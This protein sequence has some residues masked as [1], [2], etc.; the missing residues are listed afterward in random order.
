MAAKAAKR[1]L[2][3]ALEN[4]DLMPQAARVIEQSKD[5]DAKHVTELVLAVCNPALYGK[6]ARWCDDFTSDRTAVYYTWDKPNTN[7]VWPQAPLVEFTRFCVA[8]PPAGSPSPAGA[9]VSFIPSRN[10]ALQLTNFLF[11]TSLRRTIRENKNP[12]GAYTNYDWYGVDGSKDLIIASP[13]TGNSATTQIIPGGASYAGNLIAGQGQSNYQSAIAYV[14]GGGGG[15][16][17]TANTAATRPGGGTLGGGNQIPQS[18]FLP[19]HG[20]FL[21]GQTY[22]G[23]TFIWNDGFSGNGGTAQVQNVP[24][25]PTS[26]STNGIWADSTDSATWAGIGDI[27]AGVQMGGIV[28]MQGSIPLPWVPASGGTT[29]AE[30]MQFQINLWR[31]N[32]KQ[33]YIYKSRSGAVGTNNNLPNSVLFWATITAPDYYAL[34]ITLTSSPKITVTGNL[35][36]TPGPNSAGTCNIKVFEMGTGEFWTHNMTTQFVGNFG[37]VVSS[38][39]FGNSLLLTQ[40]TSEQYIG[41][42]FGGVQPPLGTEWGFAVNN[43]QATDPYS[44]VLQQLGEVNKDLKKGAY[45]FVKP[46][47]AKQMRWQTSINPIGGS[48]NFL[49]SEPLANQAFYMMTAVSN[50]GQ[51]IQQL[52]MSFDENGEFVTRNQMFETAHTRFTPEQWGLATR[53]LASMQQTYENP[54]HTK[55][56]NAEM[57]QQMFKTIG[58]RRPIKSGIG[59]AIAKWAPLVMQALPLMAMAL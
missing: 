16:F 51:F 5:L 32:N 23:R 24:T 14:Q 30:G 4:D 22:Q 8:N 40:A 15:G 38:R 43:T 41:G 26:G 53:V 21:P 10:S 46:S 55:T 49:F 29:D 52:Q 19:V 57:M 54:T 58:H 25:G 45:G 13:N 56:M 34:E 11:M 50:G 31:Y 2:A 7:T 47:S 20:Q 12:S 35:S 9:T 33:P 3:G 37:N 28:V 59:S 17:A 1:Y 27:G 36:S 18:S 48:T 44:Y 42:L 6:G 39:C